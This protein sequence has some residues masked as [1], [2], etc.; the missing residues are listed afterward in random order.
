VALTYYETQTRR[1]LQNP[2]APTTLYSTTD[3]DSWIN[4]ARGQIASEGECVRVLGQIPTIIGQTQYNFLDIDTAAT[5]ELGIQGPITVRAI[6]YVVGGGS[7]WI[8]P[9]TWDW[10]QE[11]NLNNPN[12][13]QGAPQFWAQFLQGASQTGSSSTA[14]ANSINGGNF[15]LDPAPDQ[16]YQLRCDCVCY[17]LALIDDTSPE[18]IPYL[19]TDCVPYLAA[20]Y[21]LLS[22][23][24]NARRADAEAYYKY[25]QEFLNKMW[26]VSSPT[27]N[28]F[29]FIEQAA[30]N[31][32]ARQP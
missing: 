31:P 7:K 26:K 25:Y 21:A 8:T 10:F 27:V 6:R 32:Q 20:W 4:T 3:I 29:T 15:V 1:L 22:S 30:M 28:R 5:G 12:A 23:Q 24:T 16:I 14:G 2:G 9:R 18:A 19:W 11:V 13:A 17:P